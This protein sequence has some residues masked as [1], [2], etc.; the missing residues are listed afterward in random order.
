MHCPSGCCWLWGKK[1]ESGGA[2]C[3]PAR[4]PT[5][6]L[7]SLTHTRVLMPAAGLH[8]GHAVLAH[9]LGTQAT[10]T[11]PGPSC[12]PIPH[13]HVP[14]VHGHLVNRPSPTVMSLLTHVP[15]A[16]WGSHMCRALTPDPFPG[17]THVLVHRRLCTFMWLPTLLPL[18]ICGLELLGDTG[19][20]GYWDGCAMPGSSLCQ[21]GQTL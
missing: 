12:M 17:H 18:P 8:T 6:P 1:K 3:A 14:L 13:A 19:N 20:S 5:P 2:V 10:C 11:P 15:T 4:I 9:P 16:P 7:C 21:H